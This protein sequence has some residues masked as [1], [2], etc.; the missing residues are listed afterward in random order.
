MLKQKKTPQLNSGDDWVLNTIYFIS[1]L[2]VSIAIAD[3][4]K[5]TVKKS[6]DFKS[7]NPSINKCKLCTERYKLK[8]K[9]LNSDRIRQNFSPEYMKFRI[10][11][12]IFFRL[13]NTTFIYNL[14]I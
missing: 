14:L 3:I 1:F 6:D 5:N 11:V 9:A 10:E 4:I 13:S 7:E 12:F 2:I 8:I